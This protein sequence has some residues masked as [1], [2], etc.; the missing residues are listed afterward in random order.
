M[1]KKKGVIL[2]SFIAAL[3]LFKVYLS[4]SI[5]LT[6]RD[7]QKIRTKINALKE[8]QSIIK[9]K[10]EK[11]K[12]QNEISDPLFS[13]DV[14]ETKNNIPQNRNTLPQKENKKENPNNLFDDLNVD[15]LEGY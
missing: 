8:E 2:I 12:Y 15:A 14:Y 11:L 10:I 3:L 13:Y 4:N 7:I 6:S 9:L 5:Y 1:S